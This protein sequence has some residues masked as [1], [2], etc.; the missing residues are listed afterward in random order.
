MKIKVSDTTPLQLDWM[1]ATIALSCKAYINKPS[2][3]CWIN[4]SPAG[5]EVFSPTTDWAQGGPIIER[6]GLN[7]SYDREWVYDPNNVDPDDEPGNCRWATRKEQA[8]NTQKASKLGDEVEI[9]EEL[10]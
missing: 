2:Q 10:K 9:P 3:Q 4:V 1:V 7:L 6:E 5:H 8:M